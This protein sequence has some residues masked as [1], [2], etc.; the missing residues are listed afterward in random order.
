MFDAEGLPAKDYD[1]DKDH[2]DAERAEK[3]NVLVC[4]LPT[5]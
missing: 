2:P 5:A 3:Y 1:E 4:E